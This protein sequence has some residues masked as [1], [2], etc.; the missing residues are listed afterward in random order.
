MLIDLPLAGRQFT[1]FVVMDALWVGWK[2]NKHMRISVFFCQIVISWPWF[3]FAWS[4]SILLSADEIID[5]RNLLECWNL[6][7]HYLVIMSLLKKGIS[8]QVN[9]WGWFCPEREVE[10]FERLFK[11][12]AWTS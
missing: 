5:G 10:A 2:N 7:Q 3:G 8:F 11:G 4:L 1:I 6:G 9:G 12:V